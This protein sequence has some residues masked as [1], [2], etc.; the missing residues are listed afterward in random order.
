MIRAGLSQFDYDVE[1]VNIAAGISG[2]HS[3]EDSALVQGWLKEKVP[4][5]HIQVPSISFKIIRPFPIGI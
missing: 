3:S 4:N 1:V 5:A 2:V